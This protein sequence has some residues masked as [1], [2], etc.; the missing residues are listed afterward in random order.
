M[1]ISTLLLRKYTIIFSIFLLSAI[2]FSQTADFNVQ[3]VHDDIGNTGGTNTSFAAVSS[4]NS[5][6]ALANNNRKSNAGPDE[7]GGNLD[8]NDVSGARV[9]TANGTLTYYR[10]SGSSG[11]DM[12]FNTS[13][14]E[15]MGAPGGDNE[16][17]IR[18]RYIVSLNGTNNSTTQGL[19]GITNANNCIPFITGIRNDANDQDSD[20]GTAIAYLEDASTLRI[21]KGSNANNVVVY[22]TLVEF[23]G[24][25]WNVLHGDS[26]NAADDTG[27]I[28]LRNGSDG[29]GTATNVSNWN[30][31][32][33]FGQHRGD[34]TTSGVND[35]LA[36]NWPVFDPGSNN[37]RVDWTFNSNHDS[38][39][40]NSNRHFVHVLAND[41]MNV[42]RY[43]DTNN[44]AGETT[45]NI[46]SAGLSS[47]NEALIVGSSI[48]SGG[49]QAY[50]RGWRNYYIKS[51]TQ[52][53]HWSHRSGNSMSHEI[54]I[55][56]LSGLTS[57]NYCSSWGTTTYDTGIT[58]VT[59]NTI[60]N[61]DGSPKD[62]GYEDFTS[63]S[64]S[65]AQSTS[66]NLSVSVDTDGGYQVHTF[67]WI[68]WN[69][70]SDFLDAG[71]I[72]DL[73]NTNVD[74]PIAA[75]PITIPGTASLG[76][77]RMRISTKYNSDP[78]SCDTDI[79]G[80][81]EDYTVNITGGSPIPEINVQ[82]NAVTINDGDTT[83][84]IADDTDFGTVNTTG[85]TNVEQTFTIQ[86]TGSAALS[87]GS[88]TIGGAYSGDFTLTTSPATS[89]AAS[90]STTFVIRFNPSA[91]ALR[92]ASVSIVNG[93]SDENPYNFNIQGTGSTPAPE[94]NILGN[95]TTIVDGDTTPDFSDDTD[96]GTVDITDG[97]N[98]NIFIIQNNGTLDLTLSGGFP[99]VTI[100]GTHSADFTLTTIPSSVIN[101]SGNTTF[102]ITFNP[103]ALGLR[104]A[105]IT[106]AK[107]DNDGA[108]YNFNIQGTGY[109]APPCGS[110][111]LHS[112]TF[113]SGLEG[114]TSG[115]GDAVRVNN[116]TWAFNGAYSLRVRDDDAAGNAS[117]FSS[118]LF[119][120]SSY[121]KI[122]FKF[123]FKPDGMETSEDFFIEYS[124]DSGSNWSIIGT[125]VSGIVANKNADFE[126]T[127]TPIGYSKTVTLF[128]T[129]HTFPAGNNAQFRVRCDANENDDMI[130]LDDITISATS[131]CTPTEAPG[132][133]ASDLDL[134][135]KADQV[136]GITY[137]ADGSAVSQWADNGKGNNANV[138][139]T[140]QAPVYRNSI[141]RNI[142][143]NP[144]IDFTNDNTTANR[145]MT[146]VIN[147]GSRQE[148]QGTGGFNTNDIFIVLMPDP[149]IT[150]TMIPLDTFT[151]RDPDGQTYTEDVTGLGYGAY[152]GRFSNER[153]T[154]CIATTNENSTTSPENGY[155]RADTNSGTDYNQIQIVNIRQNT[156]DTDM[157]LYF[158]ANQVGNETNDISKYKMINN[159][160]F[161]LGRSQYWNGSFDGRIAE[162]ITYGA[163]Q[164]DVNLTQE[165]NRVQSYLAIKYGI[166]LGVNG[167]TQDYVNSDGNVIWDQSTD[168]GVYNYDIA[169]IG[170]DDAS[171][172]NQKQ[173]RSVND[174]FDGADPI[175]SRTQGILTMGLNDIYNT[176]RDHI[177]S[178]PTT[179]DDKQFLVWGNNGANLNLAATT[180]SVN[181]SAGVSPALTTNVSFTAM[182]RVW[183]V[184]ETGGDI[185]SVKVRIP[186]SAIRNIT[187]PGSFYMFVS[188]TGVFD[189]TADYTVMTADGNGNLETNYDFDG[190]K[191]ITFGYAPQVVVERSVYFDGNMDY[192]DVEDKLNLNSSGFTISAWIKRDAA[193]SGTKSIVSKRDVSF[194]T[195][196][197]FRILN[198]N[199]LNI[200]WKNP[201]SRTLTSATSIPDDEWHHVAAIY[202]GSNV[203]LYIDGIEDASANLT[204]PIDTNDSFFIAAA[205]KNSPS[206]YFRGNIDEV[207]VWDTELTPIQLRFMMNQEIEDNSNFIAGKT[208]PTTMTKNDV[209]LIPWSQ[210]A[211]YYPMSVYT[212]TNTEDASGHGNQG[213]L[214][215]LNTLDRQ[216][217]PLPYVSQADGD[218]S[219]S[220]T[221]LN[222]TVQ[223]LPN[224]LSI[225]DGSTPID[226]NIIR[227]SH[228]ITIDTE[229]V[230]G[231]DR[232]V[233]GLYVDAG[234]LTVD[235]NNT[236][237]LAGNSLTV[238]HYLKLDG[239]IDLEGQSQ[240]VQGIGSDL[241]PTSS[242]ILEKDQQ[243][244]ADV[245]TYNYW[246][247]PVGETNAT[248][249]NNS[250]SVTDVM[251][252]G[253]NPI[254]F[255]NSGYDG[256]DGS[257]ITIAD[258]WIWKFANQPDGD[259]S[260]WQHV[261]RNGTLL[262]G[263]GFT[264][265]GPGS[266]TIVD[267]QNYVFQGKPNNGDINLTLNAGNDYL[268]G[269]PYPSAINANTFITDNGPTIAGS[270]ADPLISGT[271]YFWEHWG[272]GS[273]NLSEYQGGYAT[274]NFSG[275]VAAPSLGTNDPDVGTGGTPTKIP[276]LY[277]PVSQGFFVVGETTGSIN[278]N[279]GQRAYKKEKSTGADSSVFVRNSGATAN[280]SDD[281]DA[282]DE[283]MKF[284]I[285]FNSINTIHRQLL[286]TIDEATTTGYDWSYDAMTYDN[287]MDDLYW[288]INDQQYT[289]QASNV[290]EPDTVYP[291]GINTED[292][293]L[294]TI[295]I[296]ALE[297]VPQSIGVFIHDLEDDTYHNLRESDFQFF[298]AAGDYS[299]RFELTFSDANADT[300]G[301]DDVQLNTID[302]FYNIETESVALYNPNFVNVKS[303]E[304]YNLMGQQITKIKDISELNYSEY[305]VKN[306]STGTYI[307]KIDTLNGLL[308]KKVLVK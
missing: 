52:A 118:P 142:N 239:K 242:G 194:S 185:P 113:E 62:N 147:D 265:K 18:G 140:G 33:I 11:T 77:T 195:G 206:Q 78:S 15:Y 46:A 76:S 134:W 125:F 294:N 161:W 290:A 164:S 291:L 240:L 67:A 276:G 132:G 51:E 39:A 232:Q 43:Q 186:Q 72:Y 22:I 159:G 244:T 44:D 94:I 208:L 298:L 48:T 40:S 172:L 74:G 10:E 106:I 150:T 23:T 227:I 231:R 229:I 55:V 75:F 307:I 288:M 139:V 271:L 296:D 250:Y 130:Y 112:A 200:T 211:G 58:N 289:I 167:T 281:N 165:R 104:T 7:S 225:I 218:W 2:A 259:Y 145:D 184:E 237:A 293:G 214:R 171:E 213:A 29:T 236:D 282:I 220:S 114:W 45:L 79:D 53:A 202:D 215:N 207:R 196:Y 168:S 266:G 221:W 102:A 85:A 82:G 174:D 50:A 233:L 6:F 35:A 28:T 305:E 154:Y 157:E 126:A 156:A 301:I 272:G 71:E 189:P 260:A 178:N 285:G 263:E 255:S 87:I 30:D 138:V 8:G 251:Y 144:V 49:G 191:Y 86:N 24:S 160:R 234:E 180:V 224:E 223:A 299:N 127:T 149:T 5:A 14:W 209:A 261:R 42:T 295:T 304:L 303:I 65:V 249:N 16:M 177:S 267:Q 264:M 109:V 61:S 210:L 252:D 92:T 273:H 70:D 3:H 80:E 216:T 256:S 110:S 99:Y 63:I 20:S 131:F 19:T 155:G 269:N 258:Y 137:A 107:N 73:G 275:G 93:D 89:V 292:D 32:V 166:T 98:V 143:F 152:T 124:S 26:G 153:L 287:Q 108:P 187:P 95:S 163:R 135:L 81:V 176:N 254:N 9:L 148:L 230:L 66:H 128:R 277:I 286:L 248:T 91:D 88:I 96:F 13:I 243:G 4:I 141:A 162:V 146:Y 268:I 204:A 59:F 228:N 308:S 199:V 226:W 57:T 101:P 64:T 170:R 181:M 212:Y 151:S 69:Q 97:T 197:D 283:R 219:N 111:V 279:N 270:G 190:T 192:I 129:D 169:G 90:G 1:K 100:D 103:S 25:S 38:D 262:V 133:V 36:D 278:F 253:V 175:T 119:D 280:T 68:D 173:S 37:Q 284:R 182:Q 54:Q 222:G 235:G 121:D 136:D 105:N 241:D 247:S 205:G 274:Y 300:L 123:F 27:I 183:K 31:A 117:S 246:S 21:Q 203:K 115:G 257:T 122:D 60:N 41:D 34:M 17:I 47:A 83:P 201:S 116:T 302:A 306:L 84:A 238:S 12:R 198:S 193:D 188:S 120:I 297:N 245:Y 56:D 217:A 158:N 179:F